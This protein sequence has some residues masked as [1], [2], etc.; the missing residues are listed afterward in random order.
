MSEAAIRELFRG[1]EAPIYYVSDAALNLIG[2]DRWIGGLRYINTV[3]CFD[4]RHPRVLFIPHAAPPRSLEANNNFLLAH[5]EVAAYIHRFGSEGK[6]LFWEF[7]ATTERLARA[8]GLEVCFPPARLRR[9]LDSKITTTRLAEQ[10]GVES[11]PHVLAHV[12][13]YAELREVAHSL[14]QD[15]VVQL[16]YGDTGETTFFISTEADF[17]PYAA[18]IRSAPRGKGHATDPLPGGH[19]CGLSDTQWPP[20]RADDDRADRLPGTHPPSRWLVR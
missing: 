6:A 15:L 20:H 18:A 1:D 2:A 11:V 12:K 16:P 4:G 19:G 14:G 9:H 13:D 3:N 17:R 10:A 5:P 7:D 8:L